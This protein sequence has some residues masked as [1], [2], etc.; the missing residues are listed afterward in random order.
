M[1][2]AP[3]ARRQSCT[4][5]EHRPMTITRRILGCSIPS[6]AGFILLAT[7][8]SAGAQFYLQE[9]LVSDLTSPPGG[10]PKILD[11]NLVNPWGLTYAPTG[12]FSL[13]NQSTATATISI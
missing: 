9:N 4:H 10:P 8:P 7:A 2:S 5:K 11:S 3:H 12:P 13:P 1:R 6:L